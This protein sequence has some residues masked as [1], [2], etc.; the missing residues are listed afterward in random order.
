M[1]HAGGGGEPSCVERRI[2]IEGVSSHPVRH[3]V[4]RGG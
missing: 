2:G 3:I 1:R 4:L